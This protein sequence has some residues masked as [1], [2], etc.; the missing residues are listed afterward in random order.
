MI[1]MLKPSSLKEGSTVTGS[2]E[3][4]TRSTFFCFSSSALLGPFVQL[5]IKIGKV[6]EIRKI[7]EHRNEHSHEP[8]AVFLFIS[9]EH[10]YIR[11]PRR[12]AGILS[13][14]RRR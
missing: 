1:C 7:R 13:D 4:W 10:F 6:G 14:F 12:H 9:F 2:A 3:I 8:R 11:Q 5:V